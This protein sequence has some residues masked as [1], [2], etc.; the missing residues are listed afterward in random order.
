MESQ[1]NEPLAAKALDSDR[2]KEDNLDEIISHEEKQPLAAPKKVLDFDAAPEIKSTVIPAIRAKIQLSWHD[3]KITAPPPG[4]PKCQCLK[5]KAFE[6]EP[7]K[8]ILRGCSGTVAPGQFLAI[9]GASGAG[10]TSLLNYLSGR[11][12][13]KKLEKTGEIKVN[14][15]SVEQVRGFSS[16]TGYVQQDDILFQS[17]TVRECLEFAAK[18]KLKGTLE[19]KIKRVDQLLEDLGIEKC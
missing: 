9:L 13:S 3:V 18:L 5:K 8:E 4:P 19:S 12:I 16:F 11:Q 1:K 15:V 14:G 6:P 17:M 7:P 10:K 2:I